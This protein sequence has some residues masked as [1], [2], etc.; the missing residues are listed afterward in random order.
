MD[1]INDSDSVIYEDFTGVLRER[2]EAFLN[3]PLIELQKIRPLWVTQETREKA[4]FIDFEKSRI[5]W[6]RPAAL[7]ASIYFLGLPTESLFNDD[8][9]DFR[10]IT[11]L[12]RWTKG[13]YVD[14]PSASINDFNSNKITIDD[15]RHRAVLSYYLQ[16]ALVPLLVHHAQKERI[17]EIIG[18]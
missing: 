16:M 4:E 14:P 18:D 5:I 3:V 8:N 9:N 6:V 15:G 1:D 12:E 10:Y 17:I 7:I 13:Q 11:T 2:L